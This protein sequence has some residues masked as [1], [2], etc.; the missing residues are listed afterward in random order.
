MKQEP[1][2]HQAWGSCLSLPVPTSSPLTHPP[3]I[4]FSPKALRASVLPPAF[5]SRCH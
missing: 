5:L 4:S 1:D 2:P 3:S